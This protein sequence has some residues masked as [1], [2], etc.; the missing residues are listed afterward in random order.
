MDR[1]TFLSYNAAALAVP[2]ALTTY[3]E[4]AAASGLRPAPIDFSGDGPAPGSFPDRWICGSESLMDNTDPPVHVH[5][6]NSHTAILRQNK[7]YSF[8][9]PFAPLYFGNDRVL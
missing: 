3:A 4:A 5:W 2:A 7:A 8:E 6:Y 1:R 9:A